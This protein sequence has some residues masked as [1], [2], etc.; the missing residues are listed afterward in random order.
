[1][2]VVVCKNRRNSFM[3]KKV[4]ARNPEL[5]CELSTSSGL[6]SK[7][8]RKKVIFERKQSEVESLIVLIMI[9]L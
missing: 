9:E 3:L 1:M 4:I 7:K 5:L 6:S 8:E 2:V